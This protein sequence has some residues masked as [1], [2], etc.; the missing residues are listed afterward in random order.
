MAVTSPP[1]SFLELLAAGDAADDAGQ[2]A[3]AAAAYRHAL[4][5]ATEHDDAP[6]A[7]LNLAGSLRALAAREG[8]GEVVQ[9]AKDA[10]CEALGCDA[11]LSEHHAVRLLEAHKP[12]AP[13]AAAVAR[14]ALAVDACVATGRVLHRRRF[15]PPGS[16]GALHEML[17]VGRALRREE[18]PPE[19]LGELLKARLAV[20]VVE[21][22]F[23]ATA[24]LC[25]L[26][27]NLGAL[28]DWPSD[29]LTPL[30]DAVMAV[31]DDSL[32]LL[33][34]LPT[35]A[36]RGKR[37]LELCCGSGAAAAV[38][39]ASGAE[40]AVAVDINPRCTAFSALTAS[41]CG[42]E[43]RAR[44]GD[45]YGAL[46][47]DDLFDLVVANPPFVAAPRELAHGM[48]T[49]AVGGAD[50]LEV[51]RR[52]LA[53]ASEVLSP[54]GRML[55]VGELPGLDEEAPAW[56][57]DAAAGGLAVTAIFSRANTQ[58]AEE[59]AADRAPL[60]ADR[61]AWAGRMREAG[62]HTMTDALLAVRRLEPGEERRV[63]EVA[64]WS[65]DVE[66]WL[67]DEGSTAF[68]RAAVATALRLPPSGGTLLP[69]LWAS[70]YVPD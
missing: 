62:A 20:E 69:P 51:T 42:V 38:C 32:Q 25:P 53:G 26:G 10:L 8:D 61:Q 45:L 36:V 46:P 33:H 65:E 67:Q 13:G 22:W 59:Y 70:G 1:P 56:A 29:T 18:V 19:L 66:S 63:L 12:P 27:P 54:G 2:F 6:A 21:G 58:T 30:T 50:G 37:V 39:A 55:V 57:A 40:V 16:G 3:A 4:R 23:V 47:T 64:T 68:V 5:A 41:V 35:S 9:E 17:V 60:R 28:A 48:S 49:Y 31:G 44:S 24:Q 15:E 52:I 34:A 43:V 11:S 14:R 7:L